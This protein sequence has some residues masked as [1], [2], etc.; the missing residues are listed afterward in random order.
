VNSRASKGYFY[1]AEQIIFFSAVVSK[2]S[3]LFSHLGAESMT[4]YSLHFC[5]KHSHLC[6]VLSAGC[7]VA[8][9]FVLSFLLFSPRQN[10][11]PSAVG[12]LDFLGMTLT[13]KLSSFWSSRAQDSYALGETSSA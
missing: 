8:L 3:A 12:C 11:M 1:A 7:W 4:L 6:F 9:C 13:K 10:K 2:V 5:S